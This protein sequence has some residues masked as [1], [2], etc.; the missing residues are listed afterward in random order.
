MEGKKI[1]KKEAHKKYY[2]RN[3]ECKIAQVQEYQ[4]RK[5]RW[6]KTVKVGVTRQSQLKKQM[7][8]MARK[9][10]QEANDVAEK[11][12]N[13]IWQQTRERVRRLPE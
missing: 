3:R 9:Q 1:E 2:E 4:V 6:A 10:K 12:K 11:R 5:T 13:K 7:K 8:V